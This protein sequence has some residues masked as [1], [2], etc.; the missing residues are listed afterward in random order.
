VELILPST[1]TLTVSGIVAFLTIFGSIIG[2]YYRLAAS[3][4]ALEEKFTKMEARN[5]HADAET[6]AVKV[7]QAAQKTT[8]AVMAEQINGITRTLERIDRNVEGLV[9]GG[10]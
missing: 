5:I 6:E 2:V 3:L 10:K 9:K 4:S 1:A 8:V 7:E